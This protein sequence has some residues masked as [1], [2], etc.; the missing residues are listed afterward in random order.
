VLEAAVIG[1]P[2]AR[3][4]QSVKLF[5]VRR[6]PDLDEG[7]LRRYCQDNLAAYKVPRIIE[8]RA[9]LPKSNVG[10]IL[11]KELQG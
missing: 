7:A 5:V 8:F 2:D 6:D 3:S 10:K 11:R 1:V 4:G 9:A